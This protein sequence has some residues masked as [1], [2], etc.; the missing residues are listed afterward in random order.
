[1]TDRH[2][3]SASYADIGA[4][5]DFPMPLLATLS[6]ALFEGLGLGRLVDPPAFTQELFTDV[7]TFLFATM[8]VDTPPPD[9]EEHAASEA[10]GLRP[11]FSQRIDPMRERTCRGAGRGG[12]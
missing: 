10:P 1:M 3:G 11:R 5:P 8:G 4:W 7:L 12:A 6:M 2:A 9:G